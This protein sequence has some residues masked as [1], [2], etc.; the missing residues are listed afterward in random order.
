MS[1]VPN[2]CTGA[3]LAKVVSFLLQLGCQGVGQPLA[4]ENFDD[5]QRSVAADLAQL[6]LLLP[7][8]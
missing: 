5:L 7:F 4:M 8:K 2:A 6:G 1:S 3:R